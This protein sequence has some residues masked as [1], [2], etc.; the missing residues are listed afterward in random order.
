[1]RAH[2]EFLKHALV[3]RSGQEWD[4]DFKRRALAVYG[5]LSFTKGLAANSV[6]SPSPLLE[7][8]GVPCKIVMNYPAAMAVKVNS[9]RAD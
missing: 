5:N 8:G 2:S 1:L 3:V 4:A 9:F 6:H 7:H